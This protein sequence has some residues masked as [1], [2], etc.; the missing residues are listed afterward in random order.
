MTYDWIDKF[1]EDNS[2][3]EPKTV[4]NWLKEEQA[5]QIPTDANELRNYKIKMGTTFA[6]ETLK[7][8]SLDEFKTLVGPL[9]DALEPGE[10]LPL[11]APIW[12][13]SIKQ[14]FQIDP[15]LEI[16][17]PYTLPN[18]DTELFQYG[19]DK[20]IKRVLRLALTWK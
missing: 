8:L 2:V 19:F 11:D 1:H 3:V 9:V 5:E 15:E 18:D 14:R 16:P 10:C 4:G 20:E 13:D 7:L 17:E 6:S 12:V